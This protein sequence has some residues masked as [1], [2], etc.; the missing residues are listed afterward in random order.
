MRVFDAAEFGSAIRMRRRHLGYSQRQ[1]AEYCGCGIRF[2]SDLENGKPTIQ[3]G[4]AL[5]VVAMLGMDVTV[6][7]R[8]GSAL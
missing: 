8:D 6:V 1:L 3:L 5:D 4:K 2:I 7:P